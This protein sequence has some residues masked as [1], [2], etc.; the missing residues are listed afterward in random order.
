MKRQLFNEEKE[1]TEKGIEKLKEQ[2]NE[3]EEQLKLI[4][5]QIK[6]IKAKRKYEDITK[7]I[8]RKNQDKEI[9]NAQKSVELDIKSNK[10]TIQNLMN[11]LKEGVEI[12]EKKVKM[13]SN[14][15]K[16]E[17]KK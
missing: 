4:D 5:A 6:Y 10:N 1:M 17:I 16:F 15:Q 2:I 8:I 7:P 11:Q 14:N 13:Y 12:K 3:L 9:K